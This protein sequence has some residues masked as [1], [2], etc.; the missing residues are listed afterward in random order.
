MVGFG[1]IVKRLSLLPVEQGVGVRVPVGPLLLY[2]CICL[3]MF[4]YPR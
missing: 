3:Y 1:P 4:L 2:V